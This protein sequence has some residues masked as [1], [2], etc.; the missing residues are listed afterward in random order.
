MRT[1]C[2]RAMARLRQARSVHYAA[3]KTWLLGGLLLLGCDG[4]GP[5]DPTAGAEASG[6]ST[7]TGVEPTTTG[8]GST[9]AVDSTGSTGAEDADTGASADSTS[10]SDTDDASDTGSGSSTGG[11]DGLGTLAGECG[12]IDAT[13]LRSSEPFTFENAIDFRRAGF[14]YDQLTPGGQAVFDAGNLGGSSLHSE[15]IAFE[16]LARCEGAALLA[17]EGEIQYIDP[18]GTKTDLRV[19]IDGLPVGVSVTRAVGFP[20]EDPYTEAQATTL[21]TGKLEDVLAS[22]ANVAPED[23]WTKQILHV[24][25]YAD[26]H[27]DSLFA[28]YS[29]LAPQLT[30]DTILVVTVT[31]GDDAFI[32]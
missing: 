22:S 13:E 8:P 32:Y 11:D 16:V 21:L 17:T 14:D 27:A 7:T 30:A 6:S 24:I 25:A 5:S 29:T 10:S 4:D 1:A 3:P 19:E 2:L 9:G 23:A 12:L 15:V 20:P 31:H 18:M 28:A 26:M